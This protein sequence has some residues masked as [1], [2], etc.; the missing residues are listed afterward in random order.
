MRIHLCEVVP[1]LF[2]SLTTRGPSFPPLDIVALR[3][4]SVS[5][6][7]QG[8]LTN[9]GLGPLRDLQRAMMKWAVFKQ[10]FGGNL[11]GGHVYQKNM[12]SLNTILRTASGSQ[13]LGRA[14]GGT[15]GGAPACARNDI[16]D[17]SVRPLA[18]AWTPKRRKRGCV[19]VK[20]LYLLWTDLRKSNAQ[21]VITAINDGARMCAA[22]QQAM[23]ASGEGDARSDYVPG[24]RPYERTPSPTIPYC[25][26]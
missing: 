13:M 3:D 15:Q 12:D 23:V 16:V 24:L 21:K 10:R 22:T 11:R 8:K 18:T 14:T 5:G 17:S 26:V 1:A 25:S 7:T 19:E 20:K 6:K 4:C 2:L 9:P